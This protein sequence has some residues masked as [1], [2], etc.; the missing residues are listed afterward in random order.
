MAVLYVS[1]EMLSSVLILKTEKK[2]LFH[3][4]SYENIN[5]LMCI[6]FLLFQNHALE[7]LVA[8]L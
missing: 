4:I 6:M 1:V 8:D 2:N 7:P 3:L 5:F